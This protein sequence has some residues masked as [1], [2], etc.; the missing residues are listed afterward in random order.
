[1]KWIKVEAYYDVHKGFNS[2]IPYGDILIFQGRYVEAIHDHG[3]DNN[4]Y[5]FRNDTGKI[6]GVTHWM[7]LPKPPKHD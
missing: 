4:E 3:W 2:N 7:P 1:M 5:Y 6:D